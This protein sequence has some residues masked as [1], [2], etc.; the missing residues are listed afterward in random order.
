MFTYHIIHVEDHD[1]HKD[2]LLHQI[3]ITKRILN[4]K[5]N[6]DGNYYYDFEY[7]RKIDDYRPPYFDVWNQILKDPVKELELL[8]GTQVSKYNKPW[9]QEYLGGGSFGWH[10]HNRHWACVYYA[11]LEDPKDGTEFYYNNEVHQPYVQEGDIIFFPSYLIHRAPTTKGAKT[12]V[13][14][15]LEIQVDRRLIQNEK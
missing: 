3:Q 13:S 8:T 5:P 11:E 12:I 4:L 9:F 6:P 15:N 2:L 14:T 10:E 7:S 1:L